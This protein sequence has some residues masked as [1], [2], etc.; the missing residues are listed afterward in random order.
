MVLASYTNKNINVYSQIMDDVEF[1]MDCVKD[2]GT[3]TNYS[4]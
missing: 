1:L 2:G 3:S 4:Y